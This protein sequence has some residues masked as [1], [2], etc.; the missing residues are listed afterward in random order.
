MMEKT[1]VYYKPDFECDEFNMEMMRYSP[2]AG[3]RNFAYDYVRNIHPKRIVELGSYYG[4]S[5]FSFLQA[6]KD[7]HIDTEFYGIDTWMGD[8]FTENDYQ[9]DI[10][11]A[12][13]SVLESCFSEQNGRMIRST[14]DAACSAF[15]DQSIDVLHID[16]SHNYD[17]VK[18]DF[19]LW[20]SKVRPDGVIFFHDISSDL[21]YGDVM[22]SH[23]F[24]EE[25]KKEYPYTLEFK[26]SFG[27]GILFFEREKYEYIKS[28]VDFGKYQDLIISTD[29]ENKDT[30]RKYYF[31]VRNLKSR[32]EELERQLSIKQTHLDAYVGD[33]KE[34]VSYISDLEQKVE[35]LTE[36]CRS[37]YQEQQESAF[38]YERDIKELSTLI[39]KYDAD[40]KIKQQ[41]I[42]KLEGEV[43]NCLKE[44]KRLF[45][46]TQDL[47]E[48]IKK[49]ISEF[50]ILLQGKESYIQEL[51]STI[52]K[53]KDAEEEKVS[54]INEL[55][56]TIKEYKDN[57]AGKDEYIQELLSTIGKYKYTE[58]KRA[59]YV[60]ELEVAIKEYES[61]VAG[62][63]EYIQEL[64]S[65]IEKYKSAEKKR[66]SYIDELTEVIKGYKDNIA[67]KEIYI[68]ELLFTI[69]KYKATE[70][71]RISYISE[72]ERTIKKYEGNVAGKDEYIQEL[73]SIIEKYKSADAKKT[74][75]ISE[76]ENVK[77]EYKDTVTGKDAYIHELL[78]T[79]AKYKVE[80]QKK[81]DYIT[82]LQDTIGKYDLAGKE[83]DS[84]IAE[85]LDTITSYKENVTGKDRYICELEKVISK[86][87]DTVQGKDSYIAHLEEEIS[88]ANNKTIQI[89]KAYEENME[90]L[91][92]IYMYLSRTAIGKLIIKRMESKL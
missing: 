10:F 78:T 27:L 34:K 77:K 73:L 42:T 80:D 46:E 51:L 60:S 37:V 45:E 35:T 39:E 2:W 63:D 83:K 72:L 33:V 36:Q 55:E 19:L 4:C 57:V 66:T 50:T 28:L 68:Q 79:I 15:Q 31:E 64:L 85:L 81:L 7:A 75:Y 70:D 56:K 5:S 3:H 6:I 18:H 71:K 82:E 30:I 58:E 44:N 17:D 29:N 32:V 47:A 89:Q 38:G 69:K 84:Y 20:K 52:E 88:M 11:G 8:S 86:Y 74:S 61:N 25:L 21:L 12:Y 43:N 13:K 14:F 9:E 48:E 65:T 90:R 23:V 91:D 54:Y 49:T 1:W 22:G 92:A 76:L 62:K 24:W 26:I 16:G 41:Y 53:Y 67:G 59:T 87:A 40:S